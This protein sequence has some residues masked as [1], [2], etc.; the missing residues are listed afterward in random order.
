[1][2]DSHLPHPCCASPQADEATWTEVR[3]FQKCL[4]RMFMEQGKEVLFLETATGLGSH[5]NHALLEAIPMPPDAFSK[6]PMYFKKALQ[7]AESE[8]AQHAAKAVI[9]TKAKGLRGSIPPNFPYLYVQ[10]GYA[11]G[12]VHVIDD[13]SKFDR[14]LG[15]QVVVGLLRLPP[16]VMHRKQRA[17][18]PSVQASMAAAFRKQFAPYDWTKA[19]E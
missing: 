1:L 10:F 8:W 4:I 17:D 16:E 7:E 6:A 13:E 5:S 12:F 15:R 9:D 18:A 11:N 19:L 14:Q 2:R 3:N